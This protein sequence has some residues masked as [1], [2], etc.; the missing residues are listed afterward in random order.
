LVVTAIR[1]EVW[2]C[3]GGRNTYGSRIGNLTS[4]YSVRSG[5]DLFVFDAGRGLVVLAEAVLDAERMRGV[6]RVHLLVT[7]A[8]MD[9][10][11]GLKD[12]AWMW[13]PRNGLDLSIVAPAEAL[14]AIRRAHEPPSFV[15]LDVLAQNTL[16]RL[17]YVELAAGATMKLPGAT[18]RAVALHHYS[19]ASPDRRHLETLGYHLQID[20][21]PGVA[22]L[23]D[24]EPT[25]DTH[26]MERELLDASKLAI[27]DS[28]YGSIAEHAFGHGSFEYA[29]GLARRHPGTSVVAAHHGPLRSD[30]AIVASHRT[31]GSGCTNFT[32]AQE[33]E[34][35]RWDPVAQAFTPA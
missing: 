24:H 7:H 6:S 10:W 21:G 19:G 27:V 26:A 25:A 9:H 13:R 20:G 32:I 8:H 16:A 30:D 22:Y 15:A 14:A 31:H 34:S 5:A 12:A 3:R 33:G 2:G 17:S 18:L 29:A 1:F 4:C 28:N 35:A 23:S 11:E